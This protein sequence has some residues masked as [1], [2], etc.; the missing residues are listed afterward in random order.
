MATKINLL[1][2]RAELREQRKKEFLAV[3]GASAVVGLLV[4]AVWY[5]TVASL[6]DFQKER[7]AKIQ[8]EISLLDKKVTEIDEL[9]KQRNDMIDRMK[10]IQSLQ[11]NRPLIVHIFDELVG[12]L[13]DGV[14]FKRAERKG[15]KI[16]ISGTAESNNRVSTLMRDLN[17]SKW[18]KSS[19]LTKVQANPSF[20]DQGTDFDISVDVVLPESDQKANAKKE[21]EK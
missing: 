12:K 2:W 10:V 21:G 11:G 17:N 19:V 3:L 14:F 7:N 9:K 20:G 18:L 6:I 15:D 16:L 13:P 4:F 1:P 5:M 8:A